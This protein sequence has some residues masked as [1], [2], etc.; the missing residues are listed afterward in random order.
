MTLPLAPFFCC[1]A[2]RISSRT[3]AERIAS[4]ERRTTKIGRVV[5]S[6]TMRSHHTSPPTSPPEESYHASTPAARNR[7]TKPRPKA[8]SALL[9]LTKT[10]GS[11]QETVC[12]TIWPIRSLCLPAS[13]KTH[14]LLEATLRAPRAARLER[15]ALAWES[16]ASAMERALA[17]TGT[18]CT[19]LRARR[20]DQ[21]ATSARISSKIPPRTSSEEVE[22][23]SGSAEARARQWTQQRR[24]G[25][26]SL[27]QLVESGW[28][29]RCSCTS[30]PTVA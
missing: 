5:S 8:L 21:K 6:Y 16:L 30:A 10:R 11:R 19:T 24:G 20:Q 7:S 28:R 17:P 12:R 29:M 3:H 22:E 18:A 9:W 27:Q 26:W 1:Q 23:N 13:W 25:L 14:A 2:R 4:G 15:L